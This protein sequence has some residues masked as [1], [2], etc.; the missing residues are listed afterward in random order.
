MSAGIH[1]IPIDDANTI[2]IDRMGANLD[3]DSSAAE[4]VWAYGGDWVAPTAARTHTLVSSSAADAAA[5]TGART[6]HVRGL[7]ADYNIQEE[8]ISLNGQSNVVTANAYIILDHA[9]V[10]T[11]GSGGTNAGNITITASVDATA[12]GYIASGVGTTLNA[13]YQVPAGYT[14]YLLQWG[15]GVQQTSASNAIDVFLYKKDFGGIFVMQDVIPLYTGGTSHAHHEYCLPQPFAAKS[16]VKMRA[17][18][19]TA[20]NNDVHV[21]F[22]LLLVKSAGPARWVGLPNYRR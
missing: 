1:Y 14:G 20:N 16:I 13:W 22:A 5:G 2:C 18:N 15:A 6:L 4:D 11:A 21:T 12:Q 7:D 17:A 3:V 19:A 8:M 9:H 10:T